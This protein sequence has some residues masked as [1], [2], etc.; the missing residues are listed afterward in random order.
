M[1]SLDKVNGQRDRHSR[2]RSKTTYTVTRADDRR[3]WTVAL[4]GRF[5]VPAGHSSSARAKRGPW[6]AVGE[7]TAEEVA[8][9]PLGA[10]KVLL[11]HLSLAPA[12]GGSPARAAEPRGSG[13]EEKHH[14][15]LVWVRLALSPIVPVG[16]K[17]GRS[18]ED[19][20]SVV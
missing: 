12:T 9:L 13:C 4:P 16:N 7:L 14:L 6:T 1:H 19:R 20:K 8:P 2:P 11:G 3:S 18:E 15:L 17:P 10:P 5:H